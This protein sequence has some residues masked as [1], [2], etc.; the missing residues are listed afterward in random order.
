V[1]LGAVVAVPR[2]QAAIHAYHQAGVHTA[3]AQAQL[4]RVVSQSVS[5]VDVSA[6]V[7]DGMIASL[8]TARG[9]APHLRGRGPRLT[10]THGAGVAVGWDMK[11]TS[12]LRTRL[13]RPRVR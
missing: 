6:L 10:I 13:G 1:N 12:E 5:A 4:R 11:V 7:P 2:V 8:A 3:Q 9:S